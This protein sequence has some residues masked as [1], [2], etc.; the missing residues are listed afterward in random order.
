MATHSETRHWYGLKAFN[1][2]P[3]NIKSQL[4]QGENT[5]IS[6]SVSFDE[7]TGTIKESYT[8]TY[9]EAYDSSEIDRVADH[10]KSANAYAYPAVEFATYL[11]ARGIT[12]LT[13]VFKVETYTYT[14]T[15]PVVVTPPTH[16]E[17]QNPVVVPTTNPGYN[18]ETS[19]IGSRVVDLG[20]S[21]DYHDDG[22]IHV[23]GVGLYSSGRVSTDPQDTIKNALS[24]NDVTSKYL[25]KPKQGIKTKILVDNQPISAIVVNYAATT[26]GQRKLEAV[27]SRYYS[28]FSKGTEPV[29][30]R[31]V[32]NR[33]AAS[34]GV[35]DWEVGAPTVNGTVLY[36]VK[37]FLKVQDK[38][39]LVP[40]WI[41]PGTGSDTGLIRNYLHSDADSGDDAPWRT[42]DD[43]DGRS[44]QCYMW[45]LVTPG[46]KV[47]ETSLGFVVNTKEPKLD[48][49]SFDFDY[50]STANLDGS[51]GTN[52]VS[53]IELY[54]EIAGWEG[55]V[56]RS[57][58]RD[59][60]RDQWGVYLL[61]HIKFKQAVETV[62]WTY[63]P[64]SF[65][66]IPFKYTTDKNPRLDYKW[67]LKNVNYID[68]YWDQF[69]YYGYD[70][71]YESSLYL[72]TNYVMLS[73]IDN[74]TYVPNTKLLDAFDSN[75]EPV[76]KVVPY[77]N[78]LLTFTTTSTSLFQG[79]V[80]DTKILVHSS[81]GLPLKYRNTPQVISSSVMF[82]NTDSVFAFIPAAG[83]EG[84]ESLQIRD[85]AQQVKE[86][87]KV[88]EADPTLVNI[89]STTFHNS[90]YWLIYTLKNNTIIFKYNWTNFCWTVDEYPTSLVSF[91]KISNDI[92]VASD[93][94]GNLYEMLSNNSDEY[95]NKYIDA[96]SK[97]D[98]VELDQ[99]YEANKVKKLFFDLKDDLAKIPAKKADGTYDINEALKGHWQDT[100]YYKPDP[101]RSSE[102]ETVNSNSSRL[103]ITNQYNWLYGSNQYP[104]NYEFE[105]G[106]RRPSLDTDIITD[107]VTVLVGNNSDQPITDQVL[108][109]YTDGFKLQDHLVDVDAGAAAISES[110]PQLQWGF[111][112][113]RYER[114]VPTKH[115]KKVRKSVSTLD[116][117]LKGK[118]T[119]KLFL[120]GIQF[121]YRPSGRKSR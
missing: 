1:D 109:I 19:T 23:S 104:I 49:L 3:S 34:S 40:D 112:F 94:Y 65:E 85:V 50:S 114:P 91:H 62:D 75:N 99:I 107:D 81:V 41:G 30:T 96:L 6:D 17:V 90:E 53:S 11:R 14:W 4:P 18:R 8:I 31:P 28:E 26:G 15:D 60:N 58:G 101:F 86:Y 97:V 119:N 82:K 52:K 88:V 47:A 56:Y 44:D 39:D 43:I 68:A 24:V 2:L 79:R 32:L 16:T 45:N 69:V 42:V 7:A 70:R 102:V 33:Y 48:E 12:N 55:E 87:L 111:N 77:K 71:F 66:G 5:I 78:G 10:S 84:A 76:T 20:L 35:Y 80:P 103:A 98:R 83:V 106:A 113:S 72:P 61:N 93:V 89:T 108:S 21:G 63:R 38:T 92:I 25:D 54:F 100:L 110:S 27:A 67:D 116:V 95:Y 105:L 120:D 74:P 115:S 118:V 59:I 13:N 73:N 36:E 9:K 57:S 121:R 117:H 64:S 29:I 51:F 22:D 37:D 46:G